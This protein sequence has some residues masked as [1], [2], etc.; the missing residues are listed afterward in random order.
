MAE[1]EELLGLQERS[2]YWAKIRKME[3]VQKQCDEYVPPHL[4]LEDMVEKQM[5][6]ARDAGVVTWT[7][8][9]ED[10]YE[11][12]CSLEA[13]REFMQLTAKRQLME[14]Q[15]MQ[16]KR[17][18]PVKPENVVVEAILKDLDGAMAIL[19]EGRPFLNEE[20]RK[21][22]VEKV[23]AAYKEEVNHPAHYN[24]GGIEV[25]DAIEAWGL[26]F[27]DGNVVKYIVRAPHKGTLIKDLKK[28]LWYLNRH[29]ANM[30]KKKG[31]EQ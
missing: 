4:R 2:A 20:E 27:N 24:A 18:N 25:I 6:A 23:R 9:D 14:E 31:V 10:T 30:E 5:A 17:D 12:L 13:V 16:A 26:G 1:Q 28:A 15:E 19:R 21:R 3:R 11:R 29:I 8:E 22:V 7:S